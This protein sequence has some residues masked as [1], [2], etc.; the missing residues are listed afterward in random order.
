MGVSV[1][2]ALAINLLFIKLQ[3]NNE[4]DGIAAC[5]LPLAACHLPAFLLPAWSYQKL[6]RNN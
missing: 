3:I 4:T 6:Y 2:G 1:G 5:R